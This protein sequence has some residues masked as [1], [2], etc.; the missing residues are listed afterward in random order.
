M[1]SQIRH[2]HQLDYLGH[3]GYTAQYAC[4]TCGD[5]FLQNEECQ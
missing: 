3:E 4:P 5:L 2:V 1:E